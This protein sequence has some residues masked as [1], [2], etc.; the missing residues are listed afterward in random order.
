MS[1]LLEVKNL[2]YIYGKNT[3]YEK[4]ALQDINFTLEE[5]KI[6]GIVGHVNIIKA[7]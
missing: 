7:A 6:L 2:S 5:G 1:N 4:I 3:P